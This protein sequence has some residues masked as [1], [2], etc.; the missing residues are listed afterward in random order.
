MLLRRR[1]RKQVMARLA[2]T[3]ANVQSHVNGSITFMT[4]RSPSYPDPDALERTVQQVFAQCGH[5][6]VTYQKGAFRGIVY[7]TVTNAGLAAEAEAR[8]RTG[9]MRRWL[10]TYQAAQ[11]LAG[12]AQTAEVEAQREWADAVLAE[13]EAELAEDFDFGEV[14][15]P[16]LEPSEA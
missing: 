4:R 14:Q 13:L 8:Y 15:L 7:L 16:E 2:W 10:E 9:A 12:Q 1:I 6:A 5:E 3:P 11:A